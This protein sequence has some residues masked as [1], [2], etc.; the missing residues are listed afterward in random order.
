VRAAWDDLWGDDGGATDV[1]VAEVTR[2]LLH[3]NRSAAYDAVACMR[4]VH[5]GEEQAGS[6][7]LQA[8]DA[9]AVAACARE[10]LQACCAPLVRRAVREWR[11]GAVAL[12]GGEE[13]GRSQTPMFPTA[14]RLLQPRMWRRRMARMWPQV[15]T[16]ASSQ[17]PSQAAAAM[18]DMCNELSHL[19]SEL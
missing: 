4:S 16:T 11:R 13:G 15:P 3:A 17:S 18:T 10:P 14:R 9:A 5:G 2:R 19:T 1:A 7:S 12:S 6:S 8:V